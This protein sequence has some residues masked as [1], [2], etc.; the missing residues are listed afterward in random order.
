MPDTIERAVDLS[1]PADI[2]W[3][4]LTDPA[5]L[6]DWLADAVELDLTPGGAARF[7]VDGVERVGWVEE[8]APPRDGGRGRLAFWW[9]EADEPASRVTIELEP[10]AEGTRVR[11]TEARPLEILDL[12]GIP[13]RGAGG[14]G[15]PAHGPALVAAA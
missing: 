5:W 4:A 6:R 7:V 15:G 12:V 2:V 3:R 8:V 9:Q 1:A 13:L 14:L 10:I 11:V